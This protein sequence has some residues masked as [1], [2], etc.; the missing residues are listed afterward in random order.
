[1]SRSAFKI[2]MSNVGGFILF[3]ILLG[4]AN[5]LLPHINSLV[6]VDVVLFLNRSL[7]LFTIMM[8]VGLINDILWSFY[9]PFNILAPVSSAILSFFIVIFIFRVWSFLNNYVQSNFVLP[10]FV[11]VPIAL[12]VLVAGYVLIL[13]RKG[14]PGEVHKRRKKEK[15][16]EEKERLGKKAEPASKRKQEETV[17]W[18]DVGDEF[19]HLFYNIGKSLNSFF[20]GKEKKKSQKKE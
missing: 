6:Y 3:L 4:T 10:E 20:G 17:E 12:I 13:F 9:F 5:I 1:M 11:Y 18:Q 15:E 2:V 16:L 19:K 14:K 8:L 7:V